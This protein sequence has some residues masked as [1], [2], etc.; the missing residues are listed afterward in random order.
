MEAK[1]R[2]EVLAE[3]RKDNSVPENTRTSGRH[4]DGS[5][6]S[7]VAGLWSLSRFSTYTLEEALIYKGASLIA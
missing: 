6:A 5:L 1:L 3:V 2:T 7:N 4:D